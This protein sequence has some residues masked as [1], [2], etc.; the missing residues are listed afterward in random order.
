MIEECMKRDE[1]FGKW[2]NIMQAIREICVVLSLLFNKSMNKC[3]KISSG[4]R[5]VLRTECL[6][7]FISE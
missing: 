1:M 2:I 7:T 6:W 5:S 3:V 4:S